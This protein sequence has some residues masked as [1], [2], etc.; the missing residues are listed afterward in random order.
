MN[1][2][3]FV[4]C[5]YTIYGTATERICSG[6][7]NDRGIPE[8]DSYS[9][10][11]FLILQTVSQIAFTSSKPSKGS[12]SDVFASYFMELS[13]LYK[14]TGYEL[15]DRRFGVPVQVGSIIFL[16]PHR[17]DRRWGPPSVLFNGYRRFSPWR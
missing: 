5:L 7:E 2:I 15:D 3:G 12:P 17:R 10:G 13:H 8:T 6:I 9:A 4:D 1:A 14:T 16:S 11:G